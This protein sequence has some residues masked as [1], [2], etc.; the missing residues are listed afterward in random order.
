LVLTPIE[1]MIMKIKNITENPLKARNIEEEDA[2]F[3]EKILI[4]NK[5]LAKQIE[6]R[7]NYETSLL[8]KIIVKIGGLLAIG[9]G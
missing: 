9:F 4:E 7:E 8:E 2:L 1:N 6:E 3:M 5:D